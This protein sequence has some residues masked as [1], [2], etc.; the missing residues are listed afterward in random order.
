ME[1]F[2]SR[3]RP[4]FMVFYP[5]LVSLAFL[6]KN[7]IEELERNKYQFDDK[8]RDTK[9]RIKVTD[10][11]AKVIGYCGSISNFFFNCD[12]QFEGGKREQR[13]RI[14]HEEFCVQR[15]SLEDTDACNFSDFLYPRDFSDAGEFSYARSLQDP[16]SP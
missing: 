1:Q 14:T 11:I 13:C 7:Q 16:Q 2:L 6:E 4:K 8:W 15:K 3:L 5:G 12:S 9:F 10:T